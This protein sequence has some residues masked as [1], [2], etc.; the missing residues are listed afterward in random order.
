MGTPPKAPKLKSLAKNPE[1]ALTI[2]NDIYPTKCS[3]MRGTA[4][5][6]PVNGIVPEYAAACERYLGT[7]A[8]A[9]PG[10]R[11]SAR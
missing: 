7:E 8:R 1:F 2:D 3:S 9:R 4:R 11:T 10:S 6:E 5:L